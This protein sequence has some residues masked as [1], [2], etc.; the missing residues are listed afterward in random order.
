MFVEVESLLEKV[1]MLPFF[2]IFD[3]HDEKISKPVA[4]M[5]KEGHVQVR[6]FSF[7]IS[8]K[9]IS[10]VLGLSLEGRCIYKPKSDYI[11]EI[12]CF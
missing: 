8:P 3:G 5:W 4:K 7:T 12:E 11:L 1:G 6:N 10:K 9:L 2:N